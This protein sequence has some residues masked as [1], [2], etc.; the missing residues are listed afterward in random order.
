VRKHP[1]ALTATHPLSERGH[2][3]AESHSIPTNPRFI[4]ITG[5][6]FGKWAVLGYA[7]A[8]GPTHYWNARC[9]CG[10]EREVAGESLKRGLSTCCRRCA[11]RVPMKP[12]VSHGMSESITYRSWKAMIQR[13]H[14]P[15]AQHYAYYGGRG[16]TVCD[17]WRLS[18]AD[19]LADMGERPS[20]LQSIDRY[21]DNDGGYEPGNC[22]WATRTQQQRNTRRSKG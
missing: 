3:M 19:F 7:G 2:V 11:R 15:N 13:C 14:N 20:L 17:R 4:D 1:P 10:A 16:I 18:F 8:R 12:V 5:R 21:P 9:G 22:R 6:T